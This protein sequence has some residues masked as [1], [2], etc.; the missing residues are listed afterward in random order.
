LAKLFLGDSLRTAT[1]RVPLLQYLLWAIEALVLLV[2]WG[3]SA[4]LPLDRASAVGRRLLQALGPRLPKHN[5]V[6]NNLALAFPEKPAD[7][8]ETL[9]GEIWGN[10][11]AV[12]AEFA[13]LRTLRDRQFRRRIEVVSQVDLRPLCQG[14]PAVFVAAHLGNW[15]LVPLAAAVE[16]GFPVTV[17]YAP[18]QNTLVD[19]LLVHKRRQLGCAFLPKTAGMRALFRL[20]A[21][22]QSLGF[23]MDQRVD[24][25]EPI[26]FFG[27]DGYT[28][29]GP[30]RLA[31]KFGCPLIPARVERLHDAHFRVTFHAPIQPDDLTADEHTQSIQMTRKI[32]AAFEAWIRERPQQWLCT[33]RRWPKAR[34]AAAGTGPTGPTGT[35]GE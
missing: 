16:F 20:L 35:G 11:G 12:L 27:R 15:E 13:H 10:F 33:K 24:G 22:G 17:I 28:T 23:V 30:A 34:P 4:L 6:T 18:L 2:F 29:C 32:N 26:P 8:I 31:L 3:I 9:A 21:Q 25:G 19:R 7:E 1:E 5:H 14:R